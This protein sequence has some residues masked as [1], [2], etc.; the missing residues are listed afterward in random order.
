MLTLFSISAKIVSIIWENY[1]LNCVPKSTECRPSIT[2][3]RVDNPVWIIFEI[4]FHCNLNFL[5]T[6]INI[7]DMKP[8]LPRGHSCCFWLPRLDLIVSVLS[9]V[10][11]LCREGR[12]MCE[13]F[14]VGLVSKKKFYGWKYLYEKLLRRVLGKE[15]GETRWADLTTILSI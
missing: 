9:A 10:E 5:E 13:K 4:I 14:P 3:L 6:L 1:Y 15:M 7:F 12:W 8:L 11:Y 2:L